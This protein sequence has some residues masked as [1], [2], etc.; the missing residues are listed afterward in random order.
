MAKTEKGGQSGRGGVACLGLR[1]RE[2]EK[3]CEGQQGAG[4]RHARVSAPEIV[5]PVNPDEVML[6]E[7]PVGAM[8]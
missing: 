2:L 7:V 5:E 8:S 6:G 1:V 3:L 4:R